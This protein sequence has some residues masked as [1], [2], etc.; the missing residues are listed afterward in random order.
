MGN[1]EIESPALRDSQSITSSSP[2]DNIADWLDILLAG[3]ASALITPE[4]ATQTRLQETPFDAILSAIDRAR[5]A[6][7]DAAEVALYQHWIAAN[8]QSP[9]AWAGWFNLGTLLARI[10]HRADAAT[11]YGNALLL[12]PDV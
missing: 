3:P 10:G 5:P 1:F 6:L 11:A 12:R 8:P 7:T 4:H 9:L 2:A